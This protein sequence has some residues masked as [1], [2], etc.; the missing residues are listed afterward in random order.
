ML[1]VF[2]SN[3]YFITSIENT[4]FSCPC[5]GHAH[6]LNT[7]ELIIIMRHPRKSKFLFFKVV[8]MIFGFTRQVIETD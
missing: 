8:C 4:M 7:S 2:H 1:Y 3:I 5:L 6:V